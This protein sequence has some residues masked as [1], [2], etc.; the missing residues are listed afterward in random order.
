MLFALTGVVSEIHLS[1]RFDLSL[2]IK[3]HFC[4]I[5]S[6]VKHYVGLLYKT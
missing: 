4:E 3:R 5:D 6:S 2:P 1:A